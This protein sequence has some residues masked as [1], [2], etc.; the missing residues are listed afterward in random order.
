MEYTML[1]HSPK[2]FWLPLTLL[3]Q[4]MLSSF[5]DANPCRGLKQYTWAD[6]DYVSP[7]GPADPPTFAGGDW[8]PD[9]A[10]AGGMISDS[11]AYSRQWG[12][13]S[14]RAHVDADAPFAA[15]VTEPVAGN[16][17]AEI[18]T[19]PWHDPVPMGTEQW[20]GFSYYFPSDYIHDTASRS[21]L[22]Q[23]H[24]GTMGPPV[25][26]FHFVP[27][28]YDGEYGAQ[29][30]IGRDWGTYDGGP[31]PDGL[32]EFA[33]TPIEPQAGNWYDF[34]VH[35]VW[36]AGAGTNGLTE[37]W[38]N[39][40]Q[41]YSATGA[42]TFDS[43]PND[44]ALPYGGTLKLGWYKWPW[45]EQAAIDA[46]SA[47]GA[48]EVELYIG[49]VRILTNPANAHVG[50]AGFDCVTPRDGLVGDFNA[51]GLLNATD[52]DL[53]GANQ[54]SNNLL[55]DLTGDG[56]VS[57]DDVD[58]LVLVE[59]GTLYGDANLDGTVNGK[60][61]LA[62]NAA[63]FENGTGWSTGDFDL[64]QSTNGNDFVVWNSNKFQTASPV[65]E[66]TPSMWPFLLVWTWA[67]VS[68]QQRRDSN[69]DHCCFV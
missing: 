22:M 21:T 66:S 64:N 39:G 2:S 52:I 7:G 27:A 54:G 53:L 31:N 16:Y 51:D 59:L 49:P 33:V 44:P 40:N 1:C 56:V 62:W 50:Q 24:A 18:R 4:M 60:D 37:L 30:A 6:T 17:R 12:T 41:Y 55:F 38:V 42:N 5:A 47:V 35:T 11:D 57:M 67:R 36:D 25:E 26:L 43:D 28:D 65:P 9:T 13:R 58:Q 20:F 32:E 29:L 46:S 45:R 34:V 61:F 19:T 23:L 15:G 68:A 69:H 3:A 10:H 14:I 8:I 63:K 48:E